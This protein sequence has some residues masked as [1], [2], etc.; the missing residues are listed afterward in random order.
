MARRIL[1]LDLGSHT[2]K[3]AL[4]ESTLKGCRVLGLFRQRRDPNRPLAEQVQKLCEAH[5]LRGDTVLSCLPE[6]R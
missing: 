4:I 5:N 2:L 3:A 1:T 6:M